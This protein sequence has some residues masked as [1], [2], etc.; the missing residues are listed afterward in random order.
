MPFCPRCRFEYVAGIAMCLDCGVALVERLTET[1]QTAA[2][3]SLDTRAVRIIFEGGLGSCHELIRMLRAEG[4]TAVLEQIVSEPQP[5]SPPTPTR[6]LGMIV[7]PPI[8]S[9]QV[10]VCVMVTEDDWERRNET[11]RRCV[12][13][14][15][16][17]GAPRE[18]V[19]DE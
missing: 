18:D 2:E 5:E 8:P 11:I 19:L 7:I 15:T 17:E 13:R 12:A 3:P 4:I 9:R 10:I 6:Q 16:G 14:V 1:A